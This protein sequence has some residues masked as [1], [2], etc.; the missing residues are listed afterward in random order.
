MT[1]T[2]FFDVRSFALTMFVA[3]DPHPVRVQATM[4]W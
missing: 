1:T 4:R 2:L 3:G